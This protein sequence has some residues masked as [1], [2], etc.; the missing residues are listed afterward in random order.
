ML[1]NSTP[2]PA[3]ASAS[4]SISTRSGRIEMLAAYTYPRIVRDD[5]DYYSIRKDPSH[6]HWTV[7]SR[8]KS[9]APMAQMRC[10][11]FSTLSA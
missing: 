3:H 11:C 1:I 10:S 7:I 6:H 2:I 5:E 8:Y 9:L 4:A